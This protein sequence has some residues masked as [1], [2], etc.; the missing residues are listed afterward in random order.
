[1]LEAERRCCLEHNAA[2]HRGVHQLADEATDAYEQARERI[3]A[4]IGAP[5]REI[6]F[7]TP[8]NP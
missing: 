3:G 6:V 4:F 2:V 8:P 5:S 7:T 1:M